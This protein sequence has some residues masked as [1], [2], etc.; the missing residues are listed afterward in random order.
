M[1]IDPII[2]VIISF[3]TAFGTVIFGFLV[4]RATKNATK[5]HALLDMHKEYADAEFGKC[6]KNLWDFYR[7]DDCGGKNKK[8]PEKEE[9]K[10]SRKLKANFRKIMENEKIPIRFIDYKVNDSR[11]LVSHYYLHM[12]DLYFND[13][14]GNHEDLKTKELFFNYWTEQTLRIIPKIIIPLEDELV[15]IIDLEIDKKG[16]ERQKNLYEHAKLFCDS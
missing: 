1:E 5:H 11:R 15:E 3:I 10:I 7:E 8:L 12:A 2:L 14:L 13:I 9:E 16:R 4:W 6:I